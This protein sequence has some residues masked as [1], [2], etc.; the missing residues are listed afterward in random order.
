MIIFYK[1]FTSFGQLYQILCLRC[2]FPPSN[3]PLSPAKNTMI[4]KACVRYWFLLHEHANIFW[5][6]SM[7]TNK[8][9]EIGVCEC[10]LL[11]SWFVK[12]CS[13]YIQTLW[14][15]KPSNFSKETLKIWRFW[16]NPEDLRETLSL[17]LP[18]HHLP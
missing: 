10:T 15:P 6:E 17:Y 12:T 5:F 11:R 7:L 8:Y 9:F 4:I 1:C 13:A 3:A 16:K 2:T 18:T 14:I